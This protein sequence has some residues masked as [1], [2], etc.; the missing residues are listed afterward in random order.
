[1]AFATS[2]VQKSY[3]G[4]LKVTYGDW[5]G[6]AGD[7]NGSIGVA[8]GRVYLALFTSEDSSG[9]QI[10]WPIKIS[11]S[12]SGEVTTV[13]VYNNSPVTTGRFLIIHK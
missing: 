10:M 13:T 12:T 9:A 3:F 2:N 4:N 11:S 8:G 7:A 6:A 5:S 1:M